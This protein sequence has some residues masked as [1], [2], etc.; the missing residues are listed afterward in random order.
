VAAKDLADHFENRETYYFTGSPSRH[1]LLMLDIDCHKCGTLEGAMGFA[2]YL[3]K[4]Y[5]PNL[6]Y[7]VS[8]NG[9]GVHGYIVVEKDSDAVHNATC[10]RLQDWLRGILERTS[11]DVETVEIKGTCAIFG[12]H[13]MKE[14]SLAKYPRDCRRFD[15]LAATT[16]LTV[17]DIERLIPPGHGS[18]I[19]SCG[20]GI[21]L[22]NMG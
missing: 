2:A 5:F 20:Y 18:I 13:T 3:R 22:R 17:Q 6:Y 9:N 7:E 8:T 21:S 10:K 16:H 11:F 14:G 4:L 12:P 1:T 19:A 15:E